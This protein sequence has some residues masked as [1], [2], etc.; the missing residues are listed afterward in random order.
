MKSWMFALAP[1]LM[2]GLVGCGTPHPH[3]YKLSKRI[4]RQK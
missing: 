3:K 2:V 1:L 4:Y